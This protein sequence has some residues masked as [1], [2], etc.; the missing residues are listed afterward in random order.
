[1]AASEEK[2]LDS[3][4]GWLMDSEN[5]SEKDRDKAVKVI[6]KD[7]IDTFI[8]KAV[9]RAKGYTNDKNLD[10]DKDEIVVEAV[11]TWT[12]GLL[13]NEELRDQSVPKPGD[14]VIQTGDALIAEAKEMLNPYVIPVDNN[15]QEPNKKLVI[16]T[17]F[18]N[19]D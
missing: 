13:W 8:K 3:L 16:G 11:E 4:K 1:M 19:D 9:K 17:A 7:F 6:K 2:V 18:I 5:L 10:I 15:P 14:G 12:A